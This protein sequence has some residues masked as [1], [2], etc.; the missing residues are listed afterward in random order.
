[1][2]I[3]LLFIYFSRFREFCYSGQLWDEPCSSLPIINSLYSILFWAVW[4]LL[5]WQLKITMLVLAHRCFILFFSIFV[6]FGAV[7]ALQC[8]PLPVSVIVI[9]HGP[10]VLLLWLLWD[11]PLLLMTVLP[12]P[13]YFMLTTLLSM[14]L[15]LL[16]GSL[17]R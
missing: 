17:L 2:L 7:W 15:G 12:L 3:P 16:A 9:D 4:G 8:L 1:M 5:L 13:V 14:R 6:L 11:L 10:P